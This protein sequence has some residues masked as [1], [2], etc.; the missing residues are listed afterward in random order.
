VASPL[1]TPTAK[2]K[3]NLKQGGQPGRPGGKAGK[4]KREQEKEVRRISRKLLLSPKYQK[5]LK[6]RLE[7]GAIQPGVEAM[8]WY[9]SFGKPPETIEQKVVVP[10]R[11]QH[12]YSE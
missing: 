2:S 9:Y 11:I 8:L 4:E 12:Q 10:V 6:Q 3:A 7:S 5:T 1:K